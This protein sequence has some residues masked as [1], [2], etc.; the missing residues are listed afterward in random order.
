MCKKCS[1]NCS[2]WKS[3]DFPFPRLPRW[4]LNERGPHAITVED[5]LIWSHNSND[6]HNSHDSRDSNDSQLLFWPRS[7]LS[8]MW[9]QNTCFIASVFHFRERD[10][11]QT[12][13]TSSCENLNFPS[14][15]RTNFTNPRRSSIS[16][17]FERKLATNRF[18]RNFRSLPWGANRAKFFWL[19]KFLNDRHWPENLPSLLYDLKKGQGDH[20]R[21]FESKIINKSDLRR[22]PGHVFNSRA[23]FMWFCGNMLWLDPCVSVWRVIKCK[24]R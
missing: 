11:F 13:S 21:A 3:E 4:L 18:A 6:S 23:H 24:K 1:Q 2:F 16:S 8:R 14:H 12:I 20:D 22:W 7:R 19:S 5:D 15:L 10:I 9:S 17:L